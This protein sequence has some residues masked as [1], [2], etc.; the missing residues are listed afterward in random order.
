MSG[1]LPPLP[2]TPPWRGAQLN[3]RDKFTFIFMQRR[4]YAEA[5]QYETK[6]F[7][8][9]LVYA[10]NTEFNCNVFSS[11]EDNTCR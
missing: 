11:F 10:Q 8:H 1:A 7:R 9:V 5:I 2:N 4:N 6:D 3:Q